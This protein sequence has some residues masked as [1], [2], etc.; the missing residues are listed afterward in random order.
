MPSPTVLRINETEE[1]EKYR[2]AVARIIV[3]IQRDFYLSDRELANTI[4]VTEETISNTR[5][6]KSSLKAVY[7]KRLG[8]A[9]GPERLDPFLAL[10]GGRY[11][12]VNDDEHCDTEALAAI[13][14]VAHKIAD[15]MREGKIPHKPLLDMQPEVQAALKALTALTVR[16]E[17]VRAA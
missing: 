11:V 13:L 8:E 10:L 14:A 17:K 4:D 9:F 1:Q 3:D 15:G 7:L 5:N 16:A 12:P 2:T 6:R